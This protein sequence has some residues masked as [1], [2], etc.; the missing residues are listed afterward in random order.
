[1]SLDA[2]L[3]VLA[4]PTRMKILAFL[5]DPVEA[6][7]SREDGVCACDFEDYLGLSQPTISH[8]MKQLVTAGFVD[9]DRRGRWTYYE[10]QSERFTEVAAALQAFA[11]ADDRGA[12]KPLASTD[13]A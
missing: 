9:A 13:G 12:E 10:L 11:E 8:H 3:K 4:D 1:M 2:D 5:R 6:V 7:C